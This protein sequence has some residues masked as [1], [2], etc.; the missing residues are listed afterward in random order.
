MPV[1]VLSPLLPPPSTDTLGRQP[2]Y[3]QQPYGPPGG[4]P[5]GPGGAPPPGVPWGQP[6]AP[7]MM[8]PYGPPQTQWSSGYYPMGMPQQPQPPMQQQMQPP[9]HQGATRCGLSCGFGNANLTCLQ[10]TWA[11]KVHPPLPSHPRL[12][13]SPPSRPPSQGAF[14]RCLPCR[15][16]ARSRLLACPA[17]RSLQW[18]LPLRRRL[19]ARQCRQCLS[20]RRR[21]LLLRQPCPRQRRPPSAL[22]RQ[23]TQ[24]RRVP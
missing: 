7:Q 2:Y 8:A 9:Q 23:A 17:D 4:F 21:R 10:G 11:R 16:R 24:T 22:N 3:T 13:W 20:Q 15:W 14:Q 12:H 6:Y 19:P 5:R 1:R 18:W